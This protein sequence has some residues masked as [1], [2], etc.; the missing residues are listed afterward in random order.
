MTRMRATITWE[1]DAD[2]ANYGEAGHDPFQ[3]A[4]L[5]AQNDPHELLAFTEDAPGTDLELAVEPV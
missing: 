2:P 1:Y 3:M 5:D 4:Q